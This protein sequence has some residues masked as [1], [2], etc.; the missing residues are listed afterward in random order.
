VDLVE[1]ETDDDVVTVIIPEF[2]TERWYHKFLHNQTAIL[3]YAALRAK[4]EIV[5]TSVRY[6]LG[7]N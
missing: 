7:D 6:H 5:V 1:R 4:R 3:L 2:V